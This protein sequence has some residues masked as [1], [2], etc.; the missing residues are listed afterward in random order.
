MTL[1][2]TVTVVD[3]TRAAALTTAQRIAELCARAGDFHVA[4]AGGSTPRSCYELL[5]QAPLRDRVDWSRWQVWF[6]DERACRPD[7]ASA[8]V[9]MARAALLDHVAVSAVHR[10]E[11]ERPDL[12]AAAAEYSSLL[13]ATIPPGPAGAP[14]LDLVLLGLGENGHTASL[15]PGTPALEVTDAW[16]TRGLADY[17]PFDRITLT[18]GAINAAAH[19]AFLVTGGAKGEALRGV[20]DG[21]VP[22]AH[23]RPSHGELHWILDRAAAESLEA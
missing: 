11:A 4:L 21:T 9:S 17:V 22:A 15:F 19:V 16:A 6:G 10:M 3:D 1:P 14:R 8:N 20:V 23:V 18:F 5:G 12:D 2:G 7:D 13:A